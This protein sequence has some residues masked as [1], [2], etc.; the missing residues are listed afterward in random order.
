MTAERLACITI[1]L[2]GLPHYARLYGLPPD[3]LPAGASDAVAKLA[4][5]RLAELLDFHRAKGTFFA[6]ADEIGPSGE[7]RRLAA[8][9]HEIGN[10]SCTHPYALS[11]LA[12]DDVHAEVAGGAA[13]IEALVGVRPVGFRAPG[14]TLS[15]RLLEA[16]RKS[17]HTYDSSAY[18][19]LPYYLAKAAILAL[20]RLGRRRSAAI[21][22]RPRVLWA[23]RLPYRPSAKEPYARGELELLELPITVDPIA[24][25]PFIGTSL[26][27]LPRPAARLLYLSVRRLP[28]VNLELH[29]VD[30]L[31]GSDGAGPRLAAAQRDLRISAAAKIARLREVIGWLAADYQLVPLRVAA[32]RWGATAV[33]P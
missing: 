4:P 12:E 28:F 23:P 16:V 33:R 1:D 27:L 24:R 31:D 18:P 19:A 11:R 5:A 3:E 15:P 6:I 29:G 20:M 32:E 26:C 9:G 30:L 7:L 21:L 17:G 8:S 22:D 10:H 13:R 25:V 14:Y 2:D